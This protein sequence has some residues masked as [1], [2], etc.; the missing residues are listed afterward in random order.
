MKL[1]GFL[2]VLRVLRG[3]AS[4]FF[5]CFVTLYVGSSVQECY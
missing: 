4:D 1:L 2:R 5:V 3:E